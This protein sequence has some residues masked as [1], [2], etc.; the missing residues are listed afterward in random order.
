VRNVVGGGNE[1]PVTLDWIKQAVE[2]IKV[3]PK[4]A[5]RTYGQQIGQCGKCHRPLTD[6]TSRAEGIGPECRKRGF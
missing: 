4:G 5:M 1:F 3:D 2:A 6:E